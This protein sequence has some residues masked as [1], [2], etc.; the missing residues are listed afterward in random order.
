PR[1]PRHLLRQVGRAE[2]LA[3]LGPAVA[4][5]GPVGAG[6]PAGRAALA[7]HDVAAGAHG[8][9][10]DAEVALA[11]LDGPLPGD[12]ELLIAVHLALGEI[13]VTIYGA[14]HVARPQ[15]RQDF[16]DGRLHHLGPVG[17]GVVLGPQHVGDV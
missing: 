8:A 15:E 2:E 1:L 12:P 3:G 14:R 7:P 16:G 17:Q 11:G 4:P 5:A 10:D 6:P 9:G 13:M